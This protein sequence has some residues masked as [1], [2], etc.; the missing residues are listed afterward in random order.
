MINGIGCTCW[1]AVCTGKLRMQYVPASYACMF[2][3]S[4]S[5]GE[6]SV[7]ART[8]QIGRMHNLRRV[9]SSREKSSSAPQMMM[10]M[11]LMMMLMMMMLMML[12]MIVMLMMMMMVRM[13]AQT[14]V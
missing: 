7:D 13:R 6:G 9:G 14:L 12:M 11:M 10:M 5:H 8:L 1:H 3:C 2:P 4:F